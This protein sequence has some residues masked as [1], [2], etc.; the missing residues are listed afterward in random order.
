[1][2]LGGGG[3]EPLPPPKFLSMEDPPPG[4]ASKP[5]MVNEKEIKPYGDYS[6]TKTTNRAALGKGMLSGTAEGLQ[7]NRYG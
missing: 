3:G 7:S 5:D 4:P 1:M 6:R 2:C